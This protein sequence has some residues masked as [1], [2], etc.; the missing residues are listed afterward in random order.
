M[1]TTEVGNVN[2]AVLV[3]TKSS[4]L[5]VTFRFLLL[6]KSSMELYFNRKKQKVCLCVCVYMY[7]HIHTYDSIRAKCMV[8]FLKEIKM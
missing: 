4:C 2:D 1:E 8:I 6:H 5:D 3:D 7:V